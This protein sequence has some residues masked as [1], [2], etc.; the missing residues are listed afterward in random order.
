[1]RLSPVI[2]L[3]AACALAPMACDNEDPTPPGADAGTDAGTDAGEPR[4][5]VSSA[6]PAEGSSDLYPVELYYDG[7]AS[8]PGVYHR[9]VLTVT[10]SG[11]MDPS[12]SQVMLTH[13]SDSSIAPRTLS[14]QWSSDH[15]TLTVTI[16][17]PEEGGPPLEE[18]APYALDLTQLLDAAGRPIDGAPVVGDG[19]L[20]F[21]TAERDGDLEH[22]CTHTLVNTPEER[23][24]AATKFAFPPA[25]DIGHTRY[26]LTLPGSD[27]THEGYSEFIS[28]PDVDENVTLYFDREVPLSVHDE[29]GNVEVPVEIHTTAPACAGITHQARFSAMAG[30]IIYSLHYGPASFATFEFIL[31]RQDR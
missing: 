4:A 28:A 24:A 25:T 30:D 1:M 2:A 17:A 19:K 11:P 18:K 5:S 31:E 16:P 15:R 26:R 9:K 10:F 29:I 22:A 6:Q 12:H 21:T 23:T 8:R 14:G 7:A 27:G 13:R 20:D 3:F